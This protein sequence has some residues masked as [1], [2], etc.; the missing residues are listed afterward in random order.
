MFKVLHTDRVQSIGYDQKDAVVLTVFRRVGGNTINISRD[1]HDLL[2]KDGLTLAPDDP[3]KRPPCNIQ[4][5]PVYDQ[6]EVRGNVRRQC[7]RRHHP[8]R[9]MFSIFI[10]LAFLL[11]WW[12]TLISALAIPTTLAI[13]FLFLYWSGQTLN[14]MSLGGL[15]VAVGLVIDDTVVVVENIARHL[16]PA[17]MHPPPRP[18]PQGERGP[19]GG[20]SRKRGWRSYSPLPLAGR[21]GVGGALIPSMPRRRKSPAP[22]S[23]QR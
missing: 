22:S 17:G 14:L 18:P 9:R 6:S 8:R 7:A 4:V 12:A 21:V 23:A 2:E 16:T 13:T 15:A 11:T 10:L 5:T 19:D 1:L 20:T 3:N